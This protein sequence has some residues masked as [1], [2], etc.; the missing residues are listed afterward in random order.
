MDKRLEFVLLAQ[1][2]EF[3]ITELSKRFKISRKT[4]YKWI[5]RYKQEG[6]AGLMDRS[7][8][9]K[10]VHHRTPDEIE[11]LITA[12]RRKHPTWGPKKIHVPV[13]TRGRP[14]TQYGVSQKFLR[15]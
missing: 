15:K 3:T 7:R 10:Q 5:Q 9:P 4:G 8:A 11:K 13:Q 2:G 12:E 6:H 1:T 14:D